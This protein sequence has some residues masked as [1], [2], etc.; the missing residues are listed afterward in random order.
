MSAR[1]RHPPGYEQD[2]GT[3][4][5]SYPQDELGPE[6]VEDILDRLHIGTL[7][8]EQLKE[9]IKNLLI[10]GFSYTYTCIKL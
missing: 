3:S 4:E 6:D 8:R 9:V 5:I 10:F 2:N 1:M 7:R